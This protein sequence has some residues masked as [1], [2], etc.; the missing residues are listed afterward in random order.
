VP[1]EEFALGFVVF[2]TNNRAIYD[3]YDHTAIVDRSAAPPKQFPWRYAVHSDA[4]S[5]LNRPDRNP[6]DRLQSLETL[7]LV[8]RT[9]PNRGAD[10]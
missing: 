5:A 3:W 9:P 6:A 4:S 7:V 1:T 8:E 2:M 10:E